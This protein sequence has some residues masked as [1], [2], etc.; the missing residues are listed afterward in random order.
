MKLRCFGLLLPAAGLCAAGTLQ[1][2]SAAFDTSQFRVTEFRTEVPNPVG[3]TILPDGSFGVGAYYP[4]IIRYTDWNH[5]GFADGPGERMNLS[6]GP[7]TGLLAAGGYYI[8]GNSG[9]YYNNGKP[10]ISILKPGSDVTAMDNMAIAGKLQFDY[11]DGWYH[12][13]VGIATRPRAGQPG[14]YDLVFNVGSQWDHEASTQPVQLSGLIS[15]TLDGDSLYAV[16]LNLSGG[17]PSASN[18]R[19]IASGIRNVIGM[20]FQPGTGDFYFADNAI[21]G[22]GPDADEPPQAEELNR[23]LAADFDSGAVPNFGYPNCYIGYRTGLAIDTGG[24]GCVQPF[25]ALQPIANGTV[26]GSE[27]EGAAQISFAPANFPAAF[28]NG[29]FIGF[30][31]KGTTGADNEENAVGFYDFNTSTYLHF[32]ENS[33]DGVAMPIGLLATNDSLFI[34]DYGTG[35]I[36]QVTAAAPEPGTW[37]AGLAGLLGVVWTGRRQRHPAHTRREKRHY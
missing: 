27:S 30:S 18:L 37:A 20:G 14:S 28:S 12:N 2:N 19:K 21:N 36:Y 9:D 7:K 16:T 6:G 29:I 23:I 33:Q 3:M 32:V 1:L 22:T 4:G 5:D 10:E 31:G 11:P 26:L 8:E 34:A 35:T 17:Q 24:T 13:Q 25:Y 15:G